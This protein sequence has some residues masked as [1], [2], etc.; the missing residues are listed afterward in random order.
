MFGRLFGV[1]VTC[2]L[3]IN[4]SAKKGI[5]TKDLE[6]IHA[7]A[8]MDTIHIESD[9]A[10]PL[11]SIMI[12]NTGLLPAQSVTGD[13]S[14]IGN[15]NHFKMI[16]DSVSVYLPYYGEWRFAAP[17][18]SNNTAITFDGVPIISRKTFNEKKKRYEYYLELKTDTELFQVNLTIFPNKEADIR[19]NSSHRAYIGYRGYIKDPKK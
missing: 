3:F 13:I 15:S 12:A 18:N 6:N 2:A 1:V 5:T 9:W 4:C 16:G 11:N 7:I 14:L 17:Y 10:N 19:L 8:A